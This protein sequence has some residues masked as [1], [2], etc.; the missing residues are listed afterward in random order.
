MSTFL[1]I[2]WSVRM[3]IVVKMVRVIGVVGVVGIGAVVRVLW[4]VKV[5][6]ARGE[7]AGVVTAAG[8]V[9]TLHSRDVFNVFLTNLI[10]LINFSE[11]FEPS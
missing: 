9:H 1:K 4:E 8:F 10:Q 2:L 5:F 3:V 6:R 11:N 7:V